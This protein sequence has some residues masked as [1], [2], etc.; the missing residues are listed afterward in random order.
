MDTPSFYGKRKQ[1]NVDSNSDLS[2]NYSD[3][4]NSDGSD[5]DYVPD[6]DIS[7][8][9][10]DTSDFSSDSTDT[11]DEND[12]NQGDS[13]NQPERKKR[14]VVKNQPFAQNPYVW[15]DN[16]TA[17]SPFSFSG[18]SGLLKRIIHDDQSENTLPVE[19]FNQFFDDSIMEMMVT[20]TN[21]YAQQIVSSRQIRPSSKN[22]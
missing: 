5:D 17:R 10:S 1:Q 11:Q 19:I 20:E 8:T 7:S 21:R 2:E 9:D 4:S 13:S 3:I 12:G 22:E 14:R 16:P 18:N 15:K 6:D